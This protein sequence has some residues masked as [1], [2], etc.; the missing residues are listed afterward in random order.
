MIYDHT[1]VSKPVMWGGNFLFFILLLVVM[2]DPSNSILHLKNPA[3]ILLVAYNIV[4]LKPDFTFFPSI[5]LTYVAVVCGL[6]SSQILGIPLDTDFTIG[7]LKGF[8][9]L[10]LL[11]WVRYY[12]VLKLAKISAFIFALL[13]VIVFIAAASNELIRGALWTFQEA[14]D[15]CFKLSSR[16]FLGIKVFG[17]S[18]NST[19]STALPLFVC[20]FNLLRERKHWFLNLLE[21]CLI[22][23]LFFVSGSRSTML[24]PFIIIFLALYLRFKDSKYVKLMMY[25]ALCFVAIAFVMLVYK[26]AN[27]KNETSNV[28]KYA[29]LY[30]Y[31]KLFHYFPEYFILGQG[32]G[33]YFF[34]LGFREMVTL[35]EWNYIE[36]LRI[37]GVFCVGIYYMLL[38]PIFVLKKYLKNEQVLGF[39]CSYVVFLFV[40]G[41]NPMLIG[42]SGMC[43]MM[44]VYCFLTK[45]YHKKDS[46]IQGLKLF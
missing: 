22:A 41:T 33:S 1:N 42:S 36:I 23:M 17:I 5:L 26:L 38:Y 30:S 29:H 18:F 35:T 27:D 21:V 25:P 39:V 13:A 10:F 45:F 16:Y 46:D 44:M 14:H 19:I 2:V 20:T 24:L 40:A 7:T 12:N 3:F 43:V 9:M 11:L 6:L 8:S 28:I 32:A 34:S 37:C 31:G 15:G 4:F